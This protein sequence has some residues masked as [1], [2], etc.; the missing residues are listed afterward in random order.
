MNFDVETSEGLDFEDY[1]AHM[2]EYNKASERKDNVLINDTCF[3]CTSINLFTDKRHGIVVC[4]SCGT[5]NEDNIIDD[6]AE[7]SFGLEDA[8][9]GKD[10]SRCGCPVN[11]LLEKSSMSTLIGKGGSN[12]FWLMR[13]I[14]QQNSMDYVERARWHVFEFIA[15]VG[16]INMLPPVVI[17]QAKQYYKDLSERKLSRGGVR[18]GLIACCILFAC[19]QCNVSRSVKEVAAMC[20]TET[21]KINN[22]TKI[23][24][25]VMGIPQDENTENTNANDLISRFTTCLNITKPDQQKIR[26]RLEKLSNNIDKSGILVGK[27]PSAITSAMIYAILSKDGHCVNKKVL[28]TEHKISVVTLNKIVNIIKEHSDILDLDNI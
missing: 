7:W 9:Y 24:Q 22:A 12:K 14:H 1:Y 10:P 4:T 23:F 13:K 25:D 11:P 3:N 6:S 16:E 20:E 28:S 18:K 5:V 19:K 8:M 21:S 26:R 15:R 2:E 27:T 17:N